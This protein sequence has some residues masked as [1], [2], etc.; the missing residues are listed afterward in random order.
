MFME[1]TGE[2]PF[3]YT[4]NGTPLNTALIKQAIIVPTG[5]KYQMF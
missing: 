1:Y 2:T 3:E 5:L 4:H